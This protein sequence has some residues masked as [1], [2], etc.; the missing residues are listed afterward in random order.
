[1]AFVWSR[2][3]LVHHLKKLTIY[4]S[5]QAVSSVRGLRNCEPSRVLRPQRDAKLRCRPYNVV[6]TIRLS[7]QETSGQGLPV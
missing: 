5:L 4:M 1:M 3:M 6:E 2:W 7:A